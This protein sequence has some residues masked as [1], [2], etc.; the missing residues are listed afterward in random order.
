MI[1]I[2]SSG[3]TN[4][5]QD[6]GRHGYLNIGV[7][8]AGAMDDHA[9]A[10]ANLLVG[11]A[12]GDAVLEISIF[13]FRLRLH[14]DMLVSVTGAD[15][16]AR[17]D[18]VPLPPNWATTGRNGQVLTLSP[19]SMGARAYIGCAG[20]IDIPPVLG[21]RSTD[22]K[23]GFGG[24][25]GRGLQRGDRLPIGAPRRP[26]KLQTAEGMGI[27]PYGDETLPGGE[28][29]ATDVRVIPA[30]EYD[31][32]AK[33]TQ[34]TFWDTVW[35]V[36]NEANRMGYRLAGPALMPASPLE[37]LSHGIVPGTIQVPP[38]GQP[39]IQ[40]VDANTC[41]GYPKI[42]TVI[43]SDLWKLAQTTVG[44][45][46]SFVECNLDAARSELIRQAERRKNVISMMSKL[47]GS[48]G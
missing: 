33:E 22:M 28:E 6:G 11:N 1:E 16:S 8:K 40:L 44:G 9:Y 35:T 2:L 10:A 3:A 31:A 7:S 5:V 12:P 24:H 27:L 21:A 36:T 19:P 20:G 47:T 41:G 42:G 46:I 43:A 39:I 32:F 26:H 23:S 34:Q 13:P 48:G 15:C 37:L 30:A 45:K 17:I 25:A 14:A 4:T 18:D 29:R 38:A